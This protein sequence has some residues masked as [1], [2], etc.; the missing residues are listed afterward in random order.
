MNSEGMKEENEELPEQWEQTSRAF[1]QPL[2]AESSDVFVQAVMR[3]VREYV[4]R[5][6]WIRW[7]VFIRWAYP[8][9]ALS[10]ASFTL[11]LAYAMQP[12]R[13]SMDEVV[14]ADRQPIVP[15]DWISGL[16]P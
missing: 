11:S 3:K 16:Q 1:L 9:L 7:P 4:R 12:A 15:A 14:L 2:R 6:E 13:V 10:V 5:D 8:A